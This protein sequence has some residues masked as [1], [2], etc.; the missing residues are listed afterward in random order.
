M[1]EKSILNSSAKI[2]KGTIDA[3]LAFS[4]KKGNGLCDFN[5]FW[6][7]DLDSLLRCGIDSGLGEHR[8]LL[9]TESAIFCLWE[10]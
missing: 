4:S 6:E 8:F 10:G 3:S 9:V 7:G 1:H 2:G 5:V